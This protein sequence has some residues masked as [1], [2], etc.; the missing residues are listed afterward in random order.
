MTTNK[1]WRVRLAQILLGAAFLLVLV[2]V[3]GTHAGNE[4]I[5]V[6]TDWSHRHVVFSAPQNL[7]QHVLLL[8]DP[9]YVQQLVRRNAANGGIGD[10]L[11]WRRAPETPELLN[12]DWSMNMGA[13]ATLG[14]GNYPAKYSFD[15]TTANC[16]SVSN[17]DYVVYNT[18]LA[19][20]A[21]GVDASQTGTFTGA[22]T[23]GQTVTI[24]NTSLPTPNSI[25]LTASTTL[26]TGLNFLTSG[27]VSTDATNLAADILRNG[28]AI[29]VTG[30]STGLTGVVTIT[31]L[32]FGTENN[33]GI[34]LAKTLTNFT[35]NGGATSLANGTNGASIGAFD[36]LYSGC[37]GTVPSVYWAYNTG[38]T[39]VTSPSLS[40]DGKQVAFIETVG[41]D[42]D[43]VLLKWLKSTT[44]TFASPVTLTSQTSA[45]NY[46]TCT[47]PCMYTIAL[48]G[49]VA[50]TTSSP[51]YDFA[52][53]T[54]YVGETGT[55]T[56][57]THTH[58]FT[59][60]FKGAPAEAGA[61]WPVVTATAPL[62]SPVYDEGSGYVFITAAFSTANNGGRLHKI[63]ATA[64]C[65]TIGT[66]T[67]TGIL[68]PST[69][70]GTCQGGAGTSGDGANLIFDSPI[71][72]STNETVYVVIGNDGTGSSAI[73]QFAEKYAANTC[74]TEIKLGTGS[75]SSPAVPMYA[76]TFDNLYYCNGT[77]ACTTG[78][79]GHYYVCGD[80]GGDPILY[81]VT[82]SALGVI[83]GAANASTGLTTATTSCGPVVEVYNPNAGPA[84]DWIFTSVN[85]SAKTASPISCPT[86][87]GCI[88][89]FNVTAGTAISAAT[90]TVGHTA[91]AGGASGVSVDNTVATGTLAG[92][93]QVYFTP[94]ADQACTTAPTA[95]GGCA[96][97]ASQAGLD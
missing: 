41:A 49:P 4:S 82:V 50:D 13:G 27:T 47:A 34:T 22:P 57:T 96:I 38:G 17:P 3:R 71:I 6:A 75:T 35:F 56:S 58:K 20:S 90:A 83:S 68:G 67:A 11:R 31:A 93:S 21:A 64:T 91:V 76:G 10:D 55:G 73:Y 86:A 25:V 77:S 66:S 1:F 60:V 2:V 59:N 28:A 87:T 15:I 8:S 61:P 7:G 81:Q 29:G 5:H 89:S 65:G 79:A 72:D 92:A 85:A 9:R 44:A 32:N 24:T 94:L 46:Q 54:L 42:A 69:A 52:T 63:C 80:T 26:N 40:G 36:N 45:A 19:P 88:M 33:A 53:D 51:F 37:S 62:S 12:G 70:G 16:G 84:T 39:V 18:S 97:Q 95:I 78:G 48:S 30:S 23:N 14:A 74:G 43:L